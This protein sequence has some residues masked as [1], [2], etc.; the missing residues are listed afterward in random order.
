MEELGLSRL[1]WNQVTAISVGG[2]RVR[3]PPLRPTFKIMNNT[4]TFPQILFFGKKMRE[5]EQEDLP[6]KEDYENTLGYSGK[7]PL[8][9]FEEYL[10]KRKKVIE[11]RRKDLKK[12][13]DDKGYYLEIDKVV[14]LN[15]E[16]LELK[17]KIEEDDDLCFLEDMI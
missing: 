4:N 16:E 12:S 6:T 7:P 8:Y 11:E 2:S 5:I 13:I 3:I 15:E 9:T 10:E 1:T 17:K 14:V